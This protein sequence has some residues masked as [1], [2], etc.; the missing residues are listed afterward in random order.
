MVTHW[1]AFVGKEHLKTCYL[2]GELENTWECL[3]VHRRH[4]L[5]LSVHVHDFKM[6]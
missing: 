6:V 3:Y 2:N 5:F 4:G 1:P